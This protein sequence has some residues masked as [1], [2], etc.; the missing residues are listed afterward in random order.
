MASGVLIF[1]LVAL[2]VAGIV[3]KNLYNGLVFLRSQVERAWSNIEVI[4]RQRYDELPQLMQVLEQHAGYESSLL[5]KLA[6]ARA[7]YG[8]ASSIAQKIDASQEIS[9]ALRGVMGIGE[10][11]PE[12]KT[13]ES[14]L[15]LQTRVSEL[16]G[17]IAD[18]RESYNE[19]IA[20]FNARIEQ[21]PDMFAARML[22]Y[23]RQELFAA[24]PAER[25]APGL[26]MNLPFSKSA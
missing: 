13:N 21:F 22:N 3:F 11:Y 25:T 5:R 8:Q 4:L 18:R 1:V 24:T 23:Q 14:F 16:E 2:L 17:A 20:N 7:R 26:K 6:A 15:Q 9:L 19:A 12:L 10:A